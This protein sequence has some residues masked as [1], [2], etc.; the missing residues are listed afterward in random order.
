ME[1][2]GFVKSKDA[3]WGKLM[4]ARATWNGFGSAWEVP[5]LKESQV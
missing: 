2:V 3:R 1:P 5:F 4:C